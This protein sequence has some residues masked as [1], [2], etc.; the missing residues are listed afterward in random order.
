MGLQ[1]EQQHQELLLTDILHA[2]AQNPF[3]PAA[4]P[5]WREP[6]GRPGPTRFVDFEGGLHRIGHDGP[7]FCIDNETPAH[8]VFLQPHR[9][10]SRLVPVE[11]CAP[12][13]ELL[14]SACEAA[15]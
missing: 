14:R 1:H 11:V 9:I 8:Q 15:P 12:D 4:L 3:A 6:T 13:G 2:F 7:G 5:A 10:A